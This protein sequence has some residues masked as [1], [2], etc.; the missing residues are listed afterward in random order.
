[1]MTILRYFTPINKLFL[2]LKKQL[3][4]IHGGARFFVF[5]HFF[6]KIFYLPKLMN[7]VKKL[8]DYRENDSKMMDF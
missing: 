8:Q 7:S 5:E 4:P 1:M 3:I 6:Q 2:C